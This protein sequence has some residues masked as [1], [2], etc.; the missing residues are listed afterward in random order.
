MNIAEWLRAASRLRPE[1]PA[2]LTGAR[3]EADYAEFARRAAG[4][5]G[6]LRGEFGIGTGDRVAI[7]MAN[8]TEY[9][10]ALYAV[11]WAG[12]AAVPVNAKLHP[13]EAAWICGNAGAKLALVSRALGD[14]LA[15]AAPDLPQLSADS[16]HWAELRGREGPETPEPCADADLA[17]LFYTSGTTGRPKGTMLSHGAIMAASLCYPTDVD[18]VRAEDCELYAAPM[19]H[20]AGFY[21]FIHVRLGARHCVP[22]SGGFDPGEILELAPRL[23]NVSFFAAPTMVTRLI[24]AAAAAGASGEGIKTIVY[25]GGPMYVAD[26]ERALDLLGPRFVQIY[27]QGEAPMCITALSR[28]R[29]A[30]RSHPRW[31]E[32]LASVGVAQ[33][34]V[35]LRIGDEDGTPLPVGETGEIM[36]RGPMTMSGYWENPE[37]TAKALAGGWLR[38]GDV[39]RLDADGFLTLTDRSKDMIITGGTNVYPREV[40]EVLLEHPSVREASVVGRP[41]PDWGEEIV[42][43]VTPAEGSEIDVAELDRHCLESI[44]RFKRPKIWRVVEDLPKNAY[45]KILKT[46]L[47]ARLAAEGEDA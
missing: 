18:E 14:G 24:D 33:S 46:E 1:A 34:C 8:R 47:R 20:G 40:E 3:V 32:R 2:L 10:E 36:C 37:A 29:V 28:E 41:H 26:M 7:F 45:G 19:S 5:A 15:E 17:W 21:N 35:E 25:G 31:R 30:D 38:T 39:G 43:F 16:P 4:L 12:A 27:G 9:L 22:P 44:A 13:K 11:L 23:G 6:A 42:A